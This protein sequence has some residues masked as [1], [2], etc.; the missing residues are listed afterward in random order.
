L[1]EAVVFH[2]FPDSGN[3]VPR[4]VGNMIKWIKERDP[5]V[6]FGL[7]ENKSGEAI[8][9]FLLSP[10]VSDDVTLSCPRYTRAPDRKGLIA[11][12][13]DE[14]F[15]LGQV[16]GDDVKAL[17]KRAIDAMAK[18]DMSEVK[19]WRA[20]KVSATSFRC[21]GQAGIYAGRILKGEKPSDLPV[22]APTKYELVINLKTAKALGLD[23]PPTLLARADEVIE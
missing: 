14:R 6:R 1:D 4:G 23:V 16:D 10:G 2:S 12:Q 7:I 22:Q 15:K 19:A 13:Y 18:F 17:R 20:R 9:N 11:L 5:K 3:D 21:Y 8:V